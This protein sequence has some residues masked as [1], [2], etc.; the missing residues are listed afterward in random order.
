MANLVSGD[1]DYLLKAQ[2]IVPLSNFGITTVDGRD[3]YE[4]MGEIASKTDG[5]AHTIGMFPR[6]GCGHDMQSSS[7]KYLPLWVTLSSAHRRLTTEIHSSV[8]S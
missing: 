6:A 7:S 2:K 3:Y 8:Y 5:V 1:F 4:L